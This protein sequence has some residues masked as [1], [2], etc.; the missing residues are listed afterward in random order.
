MILVD[1]VEKAHPQL[2]TFFLSILDRGTTTDNRGDVLNF[3]NCMMFFTS[4][5][6][7]S[8]AQQGGARSASPMATP[9]SDRRT[10]DI[11]R[12]LRRA[13]KPEFVNRVR[14]IHFNR[15]TQRE[16]RADPRSRAGRDR[17]ALRRDARAATSSWTTPRARS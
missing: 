11:R 15:L 9:R 4:N 6:G 3:A 14:M 8:D 17:P 12:E 2:L 16:R 5:L 10:T 7:Y 1:E 13:L